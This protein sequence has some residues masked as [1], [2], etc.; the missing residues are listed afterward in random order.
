VPVNVTLLFSR[1]QYVAASEAYL[2][3]IERRVAAGLNPNVGSVASLFIS[4][5]DKATMGKVPADLQ[6]TLG[7]AVAK[8]TYQAY[9]KLLESPRWLRLANVGAKPQRLLWASISTKDPKASDV[10]YIK[11]LAAPFTVNTMPEDTLLAFA[12]HGALED[13][14]PSN[15]GDS[16]KIIDRF[17]QY[18]IGYDRLAADLQTEGTES[19]TKSWKDLLDSIGSKSIAVKAAG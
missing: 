4:R 14:M 8:Q 12:D 11:A 17:A 9:R 3:G 16:E 19:F 18:C 2:R 13:S 6:N 7:I 15:G 1:T 10:L 5:W